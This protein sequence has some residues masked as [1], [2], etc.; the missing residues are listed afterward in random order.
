MVARNYHCRMGEIDLIMRD[1]NFLA[2][3]EVRYRKNDD[4]GSAA[5][6]VTRQKQ[7]RILMTAHHYLQNERL[8]RD[9]PCRFDVITVSG[10]YNPRIDWIKDA[11]QAD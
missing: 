8:Y 10:Q 9:S 1:G 3:V 4:Y 11:F 2:F 7:R 6:S 5:A